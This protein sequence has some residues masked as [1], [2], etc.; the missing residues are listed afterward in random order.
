MATVSQLGNVAIRFDGADPVTT[1]LREEFSVLPS[2][3]S[4]PDIVCSQ[5]S[6]LNELGTFEARYGRV[7]TSPTGYRIDAKEF[8]ASVVLEGETTRV[9]FT[10]LHRGRR[11]RVLSKLPAP[12]QRLGNWNYLTVS[13][14]KAKGLVY[15][16]LDQAIQLR[17]LE[18]EQTFVHASAI[19]RDG[20]VTVIA[21]WGGA[22]K[23]SSVMDLVSS[24]DYRFLSD[25]LGIMTSS[26]SFSRSPKR[27]QIYPYNLIGLP[28]AARRLMAPRGPVDRMHWAVRAR[29]KGANG[30]RRRVSA[31]QFFGQD[32]VARGGTIDAFIH[33]E[34][35]PFAAP[36]LTPSTPD[37]LARR[38]SQILLHELN[39]MVEIG[40]ALAGAGVAP[41]HHTEAWR[42]RSERVIMG[43]LSGVRCY[44]LSVPEKTTPSELSEIIRQ[45][46]R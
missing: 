9:R 32:S 12:L 43:A 33:L 7:W 34:R 2:S 27:I 29:V 11:N 14:E 5:V 24:G 13:E 44:T 39:P 37:E 35:G 36:V 25:D 3:A 22:G 10:L 46:Q 6:T 8:A 26:G 23:T 30:V 16:V 1:H 21:G 41:A 40:A 17:Q 38:S 19:E 4:A 18:S 42:E 28:A 45:I 15:D 31:E 20:R